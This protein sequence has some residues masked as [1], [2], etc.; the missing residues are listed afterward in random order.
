MVDLH[1]GAPFHGLFITINP[2]ER[3]IAVIVDN[4]FGAADDFSHPQE[5]IGL[6]DAIMAH[7]AAQIVSC[8]G[9]VHIRPRCF[10][11]TKQQAYPENSQSMFSAKA[12]KAA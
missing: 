10:T 7:F 8:D 2:A 9:F 4:A 12:W 5:A 1:G 11:G 3:T 6:A